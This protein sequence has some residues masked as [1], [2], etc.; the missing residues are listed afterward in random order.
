MQRLL[1]GSPPVLALFE[2]NPFPDSP[3]RYVRA[4]LERY[5]FTSRAERARDGD[6]WSRVERGTY[7][8]P[9]SLASSPR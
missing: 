6:W 2:S 9:A 7:A 3:P 1:E 5:E 8:Y 4:R